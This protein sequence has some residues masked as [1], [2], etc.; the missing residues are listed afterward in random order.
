MPVDTLGQFMLVSIRENG[1]HTSLV[2][3]L[4]TA[5]SVLSIQSRDEVKWPFKAGDCLIQFNLL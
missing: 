5:R 4:D 2:S 1:A 3:L